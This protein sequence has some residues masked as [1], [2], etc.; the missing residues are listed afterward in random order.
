MKKQIL[1]VA[2]LAV[3]FGAGISSS[4]QAG[5]VRVKVPFDFAAY[6]KT[7]SAGEYT[8]IASAGQIQIEDASG[9]VT[10]SMLANN[11]S[12]RSAGSNGQVIF[13]CYRERC[14]LSEVWSPA[15]DYG[16]QLLTSQSEANAARAEPGKYFALLGEKHRPQ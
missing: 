2:C 3:T 1:I 5:G 4:A 13:H 7:Y 12:G 6:G 14:F 9:R 10:A 11:V 15:Q 16:R 8:M